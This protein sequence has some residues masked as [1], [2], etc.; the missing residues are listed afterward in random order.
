MENKK[1]PFELFEL[2]D[3]WTDDKTVT[4]GRV[5]ANGGSIH[6]FLDGYGDCGTEPGHGCP[7]VLERYDGKCSI[8]IWADINSEDPTHKID[9]S[10]ALETF[11]KSD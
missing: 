8:I 3:S 6:I 4:K 7:I 1:T 5:E 10:G 11:R 2:H 9:L